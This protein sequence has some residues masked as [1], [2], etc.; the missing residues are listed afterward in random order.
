[1]AESK[2][3]T[4]G[5]N[6][7]SASEDIAALARYEA[8]LAGENARV[9]LELEEGGFEVVRESVRHRLARTLVQLSMKIDPLV[10]GE[11]GEGLPV[12]GPRADA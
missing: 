1:V 5:L 6:N 4:T 10:V 9:M 2:E 11:G 3:G 8:V 7:W 12:G